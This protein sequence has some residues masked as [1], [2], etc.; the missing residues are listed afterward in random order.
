MGMLKMKNIGT[1]VLSSANSNVD[2]TVT[3]YGFLVDGLMISF[4]VTYLLFLGFSAYT[5]AI[6]RERG[7]T[8]HSV[9]RSI[10]RS[11]LIIAKYLSLCILALGSVFI[12]LLCT[13]MAERT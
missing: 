8:R 7:I 12:T 1:Q 13:W 11:E 6:D 3:G 9:V 2:S 5:F 10:S 4:I